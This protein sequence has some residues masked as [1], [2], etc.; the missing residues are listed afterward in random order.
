[1]KQLSIF[2]FI[3]SLVFV[4]C[5]EDVNDTENRC[6]N[7]CTPFIYRTVTTDSI[8]I[9]GIKITIYSIIDQDNF[10]SS[11][12]YIGQAVTDNNGIARM[13]VYLHDNEIGKSIYI[14]VDDSIINSDLFFTS[15]GYNL[16]HRLKT[17]D[18]LVET[19]YYYP[20]KSYITVHLNNFTPTNNNDYFFVEN[21]SYGGTNYESTKKNETFKVEVAVK[22][23]NR[24]RVVRVKNG[25]RS[26]EYKD[27]YVTRN[28]NITLNFDY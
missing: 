8:G 28:K 2:L 13:Y 21:Q 7:N 25:K 14:E 24:I 11:K 26:G 23:K 3:F 19:L 20:I 4:S 18:T 5:H 27:V 10:G 22:Q 12:R 9:A 6:Y 15:S 16:S 1:M 17:R